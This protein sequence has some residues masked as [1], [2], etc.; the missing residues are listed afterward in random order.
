MLS[1]FN[2][3]LYANSGSGSAILNNFFGNNSNTTRFDGYSGIMGLA[4]DA[5]SGTKTIAISKDGA[6]ITGDNATD[7]DFS[8]AL[9]VD[10]STPF[11]RHPVW[12]IATGT[13]TTGGN[14]VYSLNFGSPAFSISSGNADG[15]GYGNF[16]YAVPTN[17]YSLCTKNL[18]E[19]G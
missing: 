18:A 2:A 1:A 14:G 16:E 12:H 17:Y 4:V 9:K 5:T 15:N 3:A 10:I 6:W 7:T 11:A 8:N 19:Y 13:G